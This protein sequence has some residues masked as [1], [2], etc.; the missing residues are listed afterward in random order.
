MLLEKEERS[1]G[2]WML[3]EEELGFKYESTLNWG[4]EEHDET[5]WDLA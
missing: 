3:V 2:Y 4:A 1:R 5:F